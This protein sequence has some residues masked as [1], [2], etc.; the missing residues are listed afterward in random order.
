LSQGIGNNPAIQ[1]RNYYDDAS[2][3]DTICPEIKLRWQAD[4]SGSGAGPVRGDVYLVGKVA[5]NGMN[6]YVRD[7]FVGGGASLQS[8]ITW[9]ESPDATDYLTLSQFSSSAGS[10]NLGTK[11]AGFN[12]LSN[13]MDDLFGTTAGIVKTTGGTDTSAISAVA[14]SEG[15]LHYDSAEETFSHTFDMLPSDPATSIT[16]GDSDGT[17]LISLGTSKGQQAVNINAGVGTTNGSVK[18]T[19]ISTGQTDGSCDINIGPTDNGVT[20]LVDIL[21]TINI[22]GNRNGDT[23]TIG[24][25]SQSGIITLGRSTSTNTI[26]I[27]AAAMNGVVSQNINIGNNKGLGASSVIKIGDNG[28]NT[29]NTQVHIGSTNTSGTQTVQ[30]NSTATFSNGDVNIDDNLEVDGTINGRYGT[31]FTSGSNMTDTAFLANS[32]KKIIHKGSGTFTI[33]D[34]QPTAADV[35]KHWTIINASTALIHVKL[36][37]GTQYVRLMSGSTQYAIEDNWRIGR[38]GVAELVCVNNAA[39]GGTQSN[40]NFILYGNNLDTE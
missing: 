9:Y 22:A 23:I 26:N 2:I 19:N 14:L 10:Q 35:G 28:A 15:F 18:Q 40:P 11:A 20:S 8:D 32:G 30:I 3:I 21:G 37:F 29:G 24:G 7:E 4:V 31:V 33:Q 6:V 17:G 1:I 27:G 38:S 5:A 16:I 36:I 13:N 12:T 34:F 25:T 39:N